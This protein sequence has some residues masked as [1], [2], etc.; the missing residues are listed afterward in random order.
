MSHSSRLIEQ[1]PADGHQDDASLQGAAIRPFSSQ[2]AYV[3]N[4]SNGDQAI[5]GF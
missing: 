5:G 3:L 2:A 4:I 1:H